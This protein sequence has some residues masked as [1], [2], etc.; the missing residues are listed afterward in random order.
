VTDKPLKDV[1]EKF[2]MDPEKIVETRKKYVERTHYAV[3]DAVGKVIERTLDFCTAKG[4]GNA[5]K[6]HVMRGATEPGLFAMA[7]SISHPADIAKHPRDSIPFDSLLFAGLYAVLSSEHAKK[8][9]DGYT[10][11]ELE[12]THQM[13]EKIMG[14]GFRDCYIETC[15]CKNC[16]ARRKRHGIKFNPDKTDRW[17]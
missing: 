11:N 13:F 1:L 5:S 10:G 12:V 16:K 7:L 17:I 9:P 4:F 2:G 6:L 14:K 15:S 3:F 8:R